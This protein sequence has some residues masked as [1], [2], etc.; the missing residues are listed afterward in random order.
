MVLAT[1]L[2]CTIGCTESPLTFT[3]IPK[4]VADLA[5]QRLTQ[6]TTHGMAFE[7]A[8]WAISKE[9]VKRN[10]NFCAERVSFD[11]S[12]VRKRI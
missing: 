1:P 2:D 11:F 10:W 4:T 8:V 7:I 9:E 12:F 5:N 6:S 3:A